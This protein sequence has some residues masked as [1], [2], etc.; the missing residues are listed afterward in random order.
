MAILIDNDQI[1]RIKLA[2]PDF[3]RQNSYKLI[4]IA[5]GQIDPMD[6]SPKDVTLANVVATDTVIASIEKDDTTGAGVITAKADAGKITITSS[7]VSTGNGIINYVV[8]RV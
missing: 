5:A 6:A 4:P 1:A 8:Y 2:L 7:E 3:K